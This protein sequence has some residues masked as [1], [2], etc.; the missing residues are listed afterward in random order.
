[1]SD[2]AANTARPS[3]VGFHRAD[4]LHRALAEEVGSRLSA[5]VARSGRAGLVVSGG[6]TPGDFYDVLATR[7]VPWKNVEITLSDERW[8]E[9]TTDRSNE[10]LART[11]LL[12]GK[13]AAAHLVPFKTPHETARAAQADVDAAVAAMPRPF[14]VMLLGMGTDGHTASLIPGSEGLA[15]ALD[16]QDPA[17]VRAVNPPNVTA[18]GERMTLTLRAILDARWIAVLIRG[19]AKLAAY[20]SALAGH[21]VL[22]QPVRAVL[23]QS[24]VPVSIYWAE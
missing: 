1:M 14:D 15:Q 19:E 6:T 8:T 16:R 7:D 17:L 24:D 13:A 9:P 22:S 18:M 23:H 20:K 3:F 12:R 11:R 21:D 5:G 2:T 10:H 4:D